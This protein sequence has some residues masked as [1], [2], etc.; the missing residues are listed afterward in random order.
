MQGYKKYGIEQ[1]NSFLLC[2]ECITKIKETYPSIDKEANFFIANLYIFNLF[3]YLFSKSTSS[4][5]NKQFVI[6]KKVLSLN[7]SGVFSHYLVIFII[8]R[9][10]ITVLFYLYRKK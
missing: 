6:N 7:I 5:I 4:A 2:K 9:M 10:P 3:Y 1:F 8:K